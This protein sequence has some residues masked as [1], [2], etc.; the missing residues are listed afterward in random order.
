MLFEVIEN[1]AVRYTIY[2]F[3]LVGYCNYNFILYRFRVIW[4]WIIRDLE[5]WVR[6]HSRSMKL[7]PFESLGA[8]SYSPSIVT[9]ALSCIICEI[10]RLRGQKSQNFCIPHV[11]SA[12]A[13]GEPVGISWRCLML[14]KLE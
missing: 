12:S 3:L 7:V 1:N 11:F 4:R 8:V 6:R 14:I 13:G 2:D 10:W 9:V 5:I